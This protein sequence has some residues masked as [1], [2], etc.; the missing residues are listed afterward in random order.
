MPFKTAFVEINDGDV[1]F[2]IEVIND[3]V[4]MAD[5]FVNLVSGY[6]DDDG[7]LVTSSNKIFIK[8]LKG[9]F[10]IDVVSCIPVSFFEYKEEYDYSFKFNRVFRIMRLPR[11]YNLV[12]VT[13]IT[14]VF[15]G[16]TTNTMMMKVV[17]YV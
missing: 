13:K 2:Y 9:W 7:K 16:L 10:L 3:I 14:K 15:T 4:F 1:W 12:K 8:Y 6:Y 17:E 5:V 11:L